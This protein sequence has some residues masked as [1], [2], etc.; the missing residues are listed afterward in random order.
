[1]EMHLYDGVFVRTWKDWTICLILMASCVNLGC[2]ALLIGG[3]ATAGYKLGT[4]QKTLSETVDDSRITGSIKTRLMEDRNVQALNVDVDTHLGE[5]SLTGFVR[6]Q[7]EIDRA[8]IIA[9][10]VRGVK[11]V[12]SLLKTRPPE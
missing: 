10:G 2:E 1:M 5:V 11:K 6:S 9:K 3:V 4:D 12:T 8:V 7:E